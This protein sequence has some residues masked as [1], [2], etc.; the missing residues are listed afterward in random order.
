[1]A[2]LASLNRDLVLDQIA[3]LGL[4]RATIDLDGTVLRTGLQVAWAQRGYNPHHPKDPS[5]YPL[6]AHLA[7]TGQIL[8]VKNRP[9][10]VNDSRGAGRHHP[11]DRRQAARSLRSGAPHRVSHRRRIF[12]G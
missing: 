11:R 4:R 7:Q 6:L 9:G 5:Y 8:R 2:A 3:S 12:P 1:V 10:N